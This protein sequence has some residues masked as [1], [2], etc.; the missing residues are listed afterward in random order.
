MEPIFRFI[1]IFLV[2][3]FV[4]SALHFYVYFRFQKFFPK[5]RIKWV[6]VFLALLPWI[7]IIFSRSYYNVFIRII[8]SV[9]FTWL[10]VFFIILMSLVLYEV[11]RHAVKFSPE[12]W[13]KI[14]VT[15]VI[16]LSVVSIINGQIIYVKEIEIPL[17]GL[18][19]PLKVVHLTDIHVGT[20]HNSGFLKRIV[21]MTNEQNPDMVFITG[22]LFD[23]AGAVREHTVEPLRGLDAKTFFVTGNH[24]VYENLDKVEEVLKT[25]NIIILRDESVNYQGLQ[26]VGMDN[27][28]RDDMF[29]GPDLSKIE[30][31]DDIP[32]VLLYHQPLGMAEADK[33]GI[34]LQL[35]G[36]THNGQIFPF[37][38]VIKRVY[39]MIYGLYRIGDMYLYVSSG[40]GTWGPPMR[41]GSRNE[42][43][44]INLLPV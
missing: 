34:D 35:S 2:F 43:A 9:S 27:P 1:M 13:K 33:A 37:N 18:S 40:T 30:I 15:T 42:I 21:D 23:G 44:V 19:T 28:V 41:L 36:H 3:L 16:L 5:Y 24:E 31:D 25:T 32:S 29:S 11:L 22:D 7:S 12:V 17:L 10:G 8:Y 6:V 26:I 39:P 38:M 4:Y 14:I 20:I